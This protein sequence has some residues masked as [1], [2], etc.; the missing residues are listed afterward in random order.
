MP[1]GS[2]RRSAQAGVGGTDR[3]CPVLSGRDHGGPEPPQR[4]RLWSPRDHRPRGDATGRARPAADPTLSGSAGVRRRGRWRGRVPAEDPPRGRSGSRTVS[5]GG[6]VW[7]S[8]RLDRA[9]MDAQAVGGCA[10]Q[11]QPGSAMLRGRDSSEDLGRT[12]CRPDGERVGLATRRRRPDREVRGGLIVLD[13]DRGDL[14]GLGGALH[15]GALHGGALRGRV[16]HGAI[17]SACTFRGPPP[18]RSHGPRAPRSR[19]P[20]GVAGADQHLAERTLDAF[21]APRCQC[22]RG[23]APRVRARAGAGR[24]SCAGVSIAGG[25]ARR[26]C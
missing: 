15:G 10:G 19:S 16:L 26:P 23:D 13:L 2:R 22:D 18:R 5:R 21:G 4:E 11:I 1:L 12:S 24:D 20:G 7:R 9:E 6:H 8:G 14:A 3:P 17:A 25:L